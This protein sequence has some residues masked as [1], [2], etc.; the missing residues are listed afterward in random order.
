M[1]ER[2]DS[3]D[4]V[5]GA[6]ADSTRRAILLQLGKSPA[7]ITDI[8]GNFPMSLNAISKHLMVLERAGLVRREIQ[9]RE[10]LIK[11]DA[12]P[13]QE[14]SKWLAARAFWN[15]RLDALEAHIKRTRRVSY[16][17]RRRR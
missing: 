1:V 4:A 9:G 10:H 17:G 13:L 16:D 2:P 7:R 6:I 3:L 8:A 5:F 11:L 15:E 14:A 12:R